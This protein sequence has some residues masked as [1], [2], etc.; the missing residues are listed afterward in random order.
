MGCNESNDS[1]EGGG[2]GTEEDD[3]GGSQTA[4]ES[5]FESENK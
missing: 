4:G 3:S 5:I 2:V 1:T